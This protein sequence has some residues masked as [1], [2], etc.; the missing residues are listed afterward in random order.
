MF[1]IHVPSRRDNVPYR[2]RS[3]NLRTGRPILNFSFLIFHSVM[4]YPATFEQKIGF[5]RLREQVAARCTMR[6]ARERLAA[7]GFSTSAREIERRLALA[8][9]MRLLLDMEHEFPRGRVPRRRLHRR[10]TA[11]RRFV[12]RRGGGRDPAPG[13][14]R[15]RRH[16]LVHHQPRGALSGPPCPHAGR[17]GLSG[18]RAAHRRHSRPLR[19]GEGQRLARPAGDPPLHPRTRRAGGQA[20]AGR[21]VC[22]QGGG[23]RRCRRPDLDPRRQ[24]RDP[25]FGGQQ[26][27]TERLY[28]RRIGDGQNLLRRAGRGGGDQQRTARTGVR[29]AAR[30]GA[31]PH[32]VYRSDPSRRGADRRFGRLPGRDRHA[33][34]QGPLGLG[35][36]VR[37][38]D[39]LDGRQA[40][41]EKRPP[42][43]VAADAA[44]CGARDR[45]AGFAARPSQAHPRHLGTQRRRQVG[46]PENH[47]HRAV[48]VPVRVSGSGRRRSRSCPCLREHFHRHRRRAVDRQRPVDLLVAPAEHEA[49]AGRALRA[50]RWC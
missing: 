21:A 41:A 43:A 30:G 31:H 14:G 47:G 12:P 15:N 34:R 42:P 1:F 16:R 44:G 40:G 33:A 48:H 4:I 24:G 11:R 6:A 9:E 23:H 2:E 3:V 36:R 17:C 28:P 13:A 22:G 46:L 45:A 38:A 19:P 50:A 8:D 25:G 27:Q 32:G 49:H 10:Q 20:V 29:R 39:P 26:T 5:D 37:A 7:E 35:E 18:D